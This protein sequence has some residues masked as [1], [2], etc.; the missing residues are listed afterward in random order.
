M[1]SRKQ[2]S[3]II[4]EA[5]NS[6][7]GVT[8]A[9]PGPYLFTRIQARINK[10]NENSWERALGFIARPMVAFAGLALVIGINITVIA[11]NGFNEKNVITEQSTSAD[12]FLSPVAI[13]YDDIENIEP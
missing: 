6:L 7:D 13:L 11:V 9:Q 12:E 10:T 8:R 1:N 3:K 5:L 4:N 2:V